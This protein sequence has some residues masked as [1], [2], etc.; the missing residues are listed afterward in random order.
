MKGLQRNDAMKLGA[1][2]EPSEPLWKRVPKRDECGRLLPDFMMIIPRLNKRPAP[3]IARLIARIE[4]A[5]TPYRDAIVFA[6]LNL[7]LNVLWVTVRPVPG[8]CLEI[9][10]TIHHHAPE[11]LLVAHKIE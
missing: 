2:I 5:F 11:A 4:V 9:A 3:E 6:D 7:K 8:L 10:A 1:A